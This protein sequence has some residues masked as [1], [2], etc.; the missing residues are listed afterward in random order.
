MSGKRPRKRILRKHFEELPPNQVTLEM[1]KKLWLKNNWVKSYLRGRTPDL[2]LIPSL[3][4]SSNTHVLFLWTEHLWKKFLAFICSCGLLVSTRTIK[5]TLPQL[6]VLNL[7]ICKVPFSTPGNIFT[8]SKDQDIDIFEGLLLCPSHKLK[9]GITFRS[10]FF[11]KIPEK[12]SSLPKINS[13]A[14]EQMDWLQKYFESSTVIT[15]WLIDCRECK[16]GSIQI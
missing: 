3:T 6:K 15:G 14:R 1:G 11:S 9:N 7:N 8:G 16:R 2:S 4:L 12:K 5:N 10:M 13:Q